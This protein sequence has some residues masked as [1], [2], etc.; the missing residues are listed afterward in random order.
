MVGLGQLKNPKTSLGIERATCSIMPHPA[1]LPCSR[2]CMYVCIYIYICQI[3]IHSR[4]RLFIIAN[5]LMINE[6][7]TVGGIKIN[8]GGG[9][10]DCTEI[11]PQR[12]FVLQKSHTAKPCS[13][14]KSTSGPTASDLNPTS[15]AR[16]VSVVRA[17][18]MP[19]NGPV[20]RP[21]SA[22]SPQPR[23]LVAD[24]C[25]FRDDILRPKDPLEFGIRCLPSGSLERRHP[26]LCSG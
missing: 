7:R 24:T 22:H 16:N 14:N 18:G 9:G 15:D 17:R 23:C 10:E 3:G 8:R 12:H 26:L 2:V 25:S 5:Y 13:H 11:L 6:H 4:Q 1:T 21:A 20:H 19:R